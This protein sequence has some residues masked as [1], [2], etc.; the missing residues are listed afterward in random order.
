MTRAGRAS[1]W[2]STAS[3]P[4]RSTTWDPFSAAGVP[5]RKPGIDPVPVA[6]GTTTGR[7]AAP[8]GGS[9]VADLPAEYT[10]GLEKEGAA[11][12]RDFVK[13]G[14]TLVA[15][16]AATEYAIEEL[17]LPVRNALAHVRADEFLVPGSL[18]RV[19]VARAR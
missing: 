17:S 16:S 10:G 2:S 12:L 11:A 4:A 14:G 1:C 7:A 15:L 5:A 8:S 19:R 6:G 18:L 9:A 13:A 3:S